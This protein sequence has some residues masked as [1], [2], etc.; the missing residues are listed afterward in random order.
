MF[1]LELTCKWPLRCGEA[2]C[3]Q[4]RSPG[5]SSA[6]E[7]STSRFFVYHKS[8]WCQHPRTSLRVVL[9]SSVPSCRTLASQKCCIGHVKNDTERHGPALISDF[10]APYPTAHRTGPHRSVASQKCRGV[11]TKKC[12]GPTQ[13]GMNEYEYRT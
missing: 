5:P 9:I 2:V 3:S 1:D 12:Y 11:Y 7:P 6:A 8:R 10:M 4:Q 13:H